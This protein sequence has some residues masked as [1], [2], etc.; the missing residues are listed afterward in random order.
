VAYCLRVEEAANNPFDNSKACFMVACDEGDR[1]S[2]DMADTYNGNLR[3][4]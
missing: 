4:D 1:A 3:Q 2:C